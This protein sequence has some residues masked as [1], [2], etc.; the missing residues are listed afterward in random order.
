MGVGRSRNTQADGGDGC[1]RRKEAH[2]D[3]LLSVT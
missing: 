3:I 1:E 2:L